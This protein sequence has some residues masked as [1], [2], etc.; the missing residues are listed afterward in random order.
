MLRRVV[1]LSLSFSLASYSLGAQEQRMIKDDDTLR[2]TYTPL[3]ADD[4]NAS[5]KMSGGKVTKDNFLR[6]VVA[7]F[8]RSTEDRTF[9]KR[10]DIT[11]AGGPSYSKN[12]SFG[13]GL[14]ASG[15]YRTDRADSITQPSNVAI[16][17]NV[18]V[19]GFYAIG[20]TGNTIWSRNRHRVN[21]AASFSSTPRTMWGVG[22]EAGRHNPEVNYVEKSYR[23]NADYLYRVMPNLFL[24]A[25]LN[26][27]H[28]RGIKFDN[29]AYLDNEKTRY[30]A[31]GIGLIAE[32]DSR[33]FIPNAWR[34]VYLS[35]RELF[36][37]KGLG[38]CGKSLWRTT[39]TADWYRQVWKGG[40]IATDLYAEFNSEGTPWPMLAR[41]GGSNRMRG[42]YQGRYADNDLIT[43]QVELRQ[44]I[45]RRI[46]GVIWGGVG[47]VFS[48]LRCFDWSQT[49]PNYGVGLRW[50]LKKRVNVRFDY[51]FGK[52]TSGFMLN[53]NE[54]F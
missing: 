23:I 35:V 24:G 30:T 54:A 3:I 16:F 32:Y 45:W 28:T 19:S 18:S 9:E 47:N 25:A 15:L 44:L 5:I 11:F 17:A 34:G 8:E 6:R 26:F 51:G 29:T 4:A 52:Q 42:Y 7:Y 22:Y 20:I 13:I 53:I 39:V 46:G 27:Q 33:D 21:Y 14:L 37:P 12:T 1:M 49:L 41:L 38:S 36:F 48:K 40:V 2:Y 43:A 10:I 50:E 31:T